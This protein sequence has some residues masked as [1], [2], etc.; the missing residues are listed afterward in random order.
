MSEG[1][2]EFKKPKPRP[3]TIVAPENNRGKLKYEIKFTIFT[4]EN[5]NLSNIRIINL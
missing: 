4:G 2:N 3:V 1:Q 5:F